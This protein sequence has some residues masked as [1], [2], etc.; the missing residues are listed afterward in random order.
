MI[1]LALYDILLVALHLLIIGLHTIVIAIVSPRLVGTPL[2]LVAT[3]A[4]DRE[5]M[6]TTKII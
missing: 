5:I 3:L 4:P 2:G 6:T 1:V